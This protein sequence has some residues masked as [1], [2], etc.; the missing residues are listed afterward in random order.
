MDILCTYRK[1]QVQQGGSLEVGQAAQ[2]CAELYCSCAD[3]TLSGQDALA[4]SMV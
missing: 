1:R 4:V 2:Q 3:S